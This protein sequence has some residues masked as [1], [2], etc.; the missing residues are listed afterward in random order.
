MV[1]CVSNYFQPAKNADVAAI[2]MQEGLAHLCL[3]TSAMTIVRAKIE[4]QVD[5]N[6]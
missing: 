4:I 3:L 1:D 2:V 5:F 6:H